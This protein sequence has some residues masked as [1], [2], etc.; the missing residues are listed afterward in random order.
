M[1]E[2][3]NLKKEFSLEEPADRSKIES[4]A[5]ELAKYIKSEGFVS[6]HIGHKKV[7]SCHP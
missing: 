6:D 5:F 4:F 2:L 1:S 3:A 7:L